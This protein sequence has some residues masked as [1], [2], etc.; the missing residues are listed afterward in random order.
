M[1]KVIKKLK[2]LSIE[3]EM[4]EHSPVYTIE[5]MN[6]LGKE[7][8]KNAKI[9]KNLFVR[10]SKGKKHFL[11]VLSEEKRA[12]LSEISEKIGSTKLSFASEKRLMKYLKLTPGS[13]TPLAVIND[14][15][16]EVQVIIDNDLKKYDILGVHPNVNTATILIKPE[17]LEKYILSCNNKLKYISI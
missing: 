8:F 15:N 11:I 10:D 17:N 9:C 16:N 5:E 3:F 1:E 4:V 13:V 12:P 7:F 2:E 14:E 6:K